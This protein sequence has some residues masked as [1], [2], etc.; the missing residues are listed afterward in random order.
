MATILFALIALGALCIDIVLNR[1]IIEE[2]RD[3]A[4]EYRNKLQY[5]FKEIEWA[6]PKTQ[7]KASRASRDKT[8][9]LINRLE[10]K[11]KMGCA[12]NRAWLFYYTIV[13]LSIS[14]IVS[15]IVD[16]MYGNIGTEKFTNIYAFLNKI[17]FD[18]TKITSVYEI[19]GITINIICLVVLVFYI[20]RL[21]MIMKFNHEV[22][23]ERRKIR[24]RVE[25]TIVNVRL[26]AGDPTSPLDQKT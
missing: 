10:R 15:V 18:N 25:E 20:T 4:E 3:E 13:V 11:V 12:S 17:G 24:N 26:I 9:A 21:C 16:N 6:D 1:G 19:L 23:I 5:V 22:E 2:I 7:A 8:E 14:A